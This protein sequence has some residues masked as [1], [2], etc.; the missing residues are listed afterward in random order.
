MSFTKDTVFKQQGYTECKG[1]GKK[2]GLEKPFKING[3]SGIF[4]TSI[5]FFSLCSNSGKEKE[6]EGKT[7]ERKFL[8]GGMQL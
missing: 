6:K 2:N 4:P 1:K 8:S 7:L 5:F 3:S